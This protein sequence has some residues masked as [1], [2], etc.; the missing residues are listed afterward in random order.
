[1]A[2]YIPTKKTNPCPACGDTKGKCR[3]F[4][5][6]PVILCMNSAGGLERMGWINT[7]DTKDGLWGK[8]IPD[9]EQTRGKSWQEQQ[10]EIAR[11]IEQDRA[12]EREQLKHAL[13]VDDRSPEFRKLLLQLEIKPEDNQD[14]INRGLSPEE[15]KRLLIKSVQSKQEVKGIKP[16]LPGI[17]NNRLSVAGEGYLCP[18]FDEHSRIVGCQVRIRDAEDNKYRWLKGKFSS[19][20]LVNGNKEL[21]LTVLKGDSKDAYLCEGILKPAIANVVHNQTFIGASG[22]NF[23]RSPEQLK[24]I[25]NNV[26]KDGTVYFCPD[27]GFNL[28]RQVQR[29]DRATIKLV[30]SLGYNVYILDWGQLED[31][32]AGDI[33]EISSET[34][35]NATAIPATEFFKSPEQKKVEELYGKE[36]SREEWLNQKA[37]A[38]WEWLKTKANSFQ[39]LFQ[40]SQGKLNTV[41]KK[42]KKLRYGVDP[43]PTPNQGIKLPR[44][45]F[46][47]GERLKLVQELINLGWKDILERSFTGTGKSHDLNCLTKDKDKE[48]K[49]QGKIWYLHGDH[50]NPT[51]AP[52]ERKADLPS[53]HNG[54]IKDHSR[55]T[56]NGEPFLRRWD[57][58]EPNHPSKPDIPSNCP[59]TDHFNLLS[60]KGYK[61]HS[62]KSEN[63]NPNKKPQNPI[64]HQCPILHECIEEKYKGERVMAMAHSEVRAHPDSLP[65]PDDYDFSNDTLIWEEVST[66]LDPTETRS[67]Y[68]TDLD[69][70]WNQVEEHAPETYQRLLP[71]KQRINHLMA[72][73]VKLPRFGANTFDDAEDEANLG[74]LLA[75]EPYP[76]LEADLLILKRIND[77]A[78]SLQEIRWD[79][80]GNGEWKKADRV[81][82]DKKVWGSKEEKER[83]KQTTK[84]ADSYFNQEA[85]H[86]NREVSDNLP[87][88]GL[89]QLILILFEDSV[90]AKN[91]KTEHGDILGC[92]ILNYTRSQ[93]DLLGKIELTLNNTRH[94]AIAD[95]AQTNIYLDATIRPQDLAAMRGLDE[96][97][98]ITI[99]Q[100]EPDFSNLTVHGIHI[101]GMSSKDYSEDCQRR[102]KALTKA[103]LKSIPDESYAM[104]AFKGDNHLNYD[105][106]W[107][108]DSRGTNRF[109]GT[110]H[111]IA[112]G[113]PYQNYGAVKAAYYTTRGTL[114]G[115]DDYYKHLKE[116]E[117]L[118][119]IG[120]QRA[121][122][123][124]KGENFHIYL[125]GTKLDLAFLEEMG[126]PVVIS[127][128]LEW[129]S[130]AGTNPQAIKMALIQKAKE[131]GEQFWKL[132]QTEL[133]QQLG[134]TQGRISQIYR[135]LGGD[136]NQKASG[137]AGKAKLKKILTSLWMNNIGEL[138]NPMAVFQVKELQTWLN[139]TEDDLKA[140]GLTLLKHAMDSLT[141]FLQSGRP[142]EDFDQEK[143]GF[144]LP[145]ILLI[146]IA[147]GADPPPEPQQ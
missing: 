8:L 75:I 18:A 101:E 125:I 121:H 79:D 17:Y 53:R 60:T 143:D 126:I 102:Q 76:E 56:P 95:Q 27:A 39:D 107:F 15:I 78:A 16:N 36:I 122:L 21:P 118:Q 70:L 37:E 1:M 124:P 12:R 97:Q 109:M 47:E 26:A 30:Q 138:I 11:K 83:W 22:G 50:R 100:E 127:H 103:I 66:Q 134:V 10:E 135:E 13:P 144:G 94:N 58:N 117:I 9:D 5:D 86:Q 87:T 96:T 89:Y 55:Q 33:D 46:K 82:K 93:K 91:H 139:F 88:L 120:R 92:A 28:N 65:S 20:L 145:L 42:I 43:L 32:A 49:S 119:L 130:E 105:G 54:L 132:T 137:K 113:T 35:E 147:L 72:G 131:L 69:Q 141:A 4:S 90:A 142:L 19:H 116:A 61:I 40:I 80:Q 45:V 98:L 112:Y 7:G 73:K 64:C 2:K 3:T 34:F 59:E 74:K 71:I 140:T 25:L 38:F 51:V 24:R 23:K 68:Q 104:I 77:R 67:L 106:Y 57:P 108:N 111:L 63:P 146:A 99:E 31:K 62:V 52:A 44:I 129:T 48:G 6:S 123:Y 114:E 136:P 14:L 41:A 85:R 115:F 110:R 84:F 133:A 29:R 128:G 81:S